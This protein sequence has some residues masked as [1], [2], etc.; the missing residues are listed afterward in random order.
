M[1]KIT[2]TLADV[3]DLEGEINGLINNET[4]QVIYE[5]FRK[6]NL[7]IILKYD[8]NTF[9][10]VL[11][12][13]VKSIDAIRDELVIKYGKEKDGTIM[14]SMYEEEKDEEGNV[15][16]KKYAKNFIEFNNE[17]NTL[18]TSKTKEFDVPTITKEDLK[19]AGQT[20]DD[21]RVL[22]KLIK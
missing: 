15:I 5:G 22:F 2:L 16:S 17:F 12:N 6:Q 3:L 1:E 10:E 18:L 14:V 7:N 4:G 20:K 13:E 19:N 21:Y 9:G 11:K 8:I